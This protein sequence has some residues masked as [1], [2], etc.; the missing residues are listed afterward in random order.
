MHSVG[1]LL[2]SMQKKQGSCSRIT[3]S[4]SELRNARSHNGASPTWPC[5]QP[6]ACPAAPQ[7]EHPCCLAQQHAEFACKCATFS[8]RQ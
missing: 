7:P 8:L 3:L 6:A 5:V 2:A 1:I 4:D